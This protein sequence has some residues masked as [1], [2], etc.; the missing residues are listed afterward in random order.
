MIVLVKNIDEHW[1]AIIFS[2]FLLSIFGVL[3][4]IY[5]NDWSWFSRSGALLV[6]FGVYIAWLDY[7]GMIENDILKLRSSLD[8]QIAEIFDE[9]NAK[10]KSYFNRIEFLVVILGTLIW[11]YGDLL[12]GL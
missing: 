10:N 7:K 5:F 2:I 6:C 1:K 4:S 8:T 9:F 3:P 11:G 12:G